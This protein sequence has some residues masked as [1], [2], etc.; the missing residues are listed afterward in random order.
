MYTLH[1]V[2]HEEGIVTLVLFLYLCANN[3]PV[4]QLLKQNSCIQSIGQLTELSSIDIKVLSRALIARL[5]PNDAVSDDSAVLILIGEDEVEYLI[6]LMIPTQSYKKIP[7]ISIMVDLSRSPRNLFTF[8]SKD[9]VL[10]LSDSMESLSEDDQAK[11][12]LLI[13]RIMELDYD[14]SEEMSVISNSGTLQDVQSKGR[15]EL[16]IHSIT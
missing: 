7:V 15:F 16:H 10:K 5:I 2:M 9:V 13:W 6:S 11:S 1:Q 12:A 4:Y 3:P 14:G 8:A